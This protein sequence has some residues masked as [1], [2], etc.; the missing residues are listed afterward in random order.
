MPTVL[1]VDD[2]LGLQRFLGISLQKYKNDFKTILA[3]NGEEAIKVLEQHDIALL[4]TN[5]QM[6][7]VDG[8]DLLAYVNEQRHEMPCIIMTARSTAEIEAKYAALGFRFLSKPF[9]TNKFVDVVLQ[10]LKPARLDGTLRGISV[11]NFLQM[12]AL[13]QKTCIMEVTSP[14]GI[15]GVLHLEKG[16]L[17]DALYRDL[18]GEAAAFEL[19]AMDGACMSF[20]ELPEKAVVRRINKNVMAIIMEALQRKDEEY[21]YDWKQLA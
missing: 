19:I 6:P 21:G 8:H 1:I 15:T 18:D 4:V 5:L 20:G 9:T 13:E 16:E 14:W 7:K 10:A 11:A 12:L 17:W 3:N 2:D